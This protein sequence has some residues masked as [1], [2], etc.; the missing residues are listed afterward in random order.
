[1][2]T[3]YFGVNFSS[4]FAIKIHHLADILNMRLYFKPV[5]T[6]RNI[7]KRFSKGKGINRE[8]RNCMC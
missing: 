4:Y 6:P 7:S 1:M 2:F 5:N 8:W 3:F